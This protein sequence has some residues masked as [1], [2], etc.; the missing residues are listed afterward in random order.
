[1]SIIF[2]QDGFYNENTGNICTTDKLWHINKDIERFMINLNKYWNRILKQQ[3]SAEPVA[4]T[5]PLAISH[6]QA[7]VIDMF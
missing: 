3:L 6:R 1:M 5:H 7:G 4:L 2:V